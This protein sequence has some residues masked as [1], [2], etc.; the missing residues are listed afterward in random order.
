M[1]IAYTGG[2]TRCRMEPKEDEQA[3]AEF[4]REEDPLG[5]P[6]YLLKFADAVT[7]R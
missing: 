7:P 1:P 2:R 5:G 3:G 6:K 4:E